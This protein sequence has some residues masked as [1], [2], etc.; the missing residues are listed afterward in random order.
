MPTD[1]QQE[2]FTDRLKLVQRALALR[3]GLSWP[4]IA[5]AVGVPQPTLERWL[6]AYRTG[7]AEA[8]M[9]EWDNA[10]RPAVADCLTTTAV[11]FLKRKRLKC[12]STST[13]LWHFQYDP[14]C[15]PEL[16]E[17]LKNMK[18]I[19]LSL[20][21]ACHVSKEAE[22]Q[23][24]GPTAHQHISFKD[25]HNPV[26]IDPATGAER[27][28]LAGD[29]YISDDMSRNMPFWFEL[30][31]GERETRARRGDKLAERHGVAVGR[32]G[33][34]TMDARGKLLGFTLIGCAR[35]A[36]TADD[37]LRHFWNIGQEFGWPRLQWVLEK[38]VWC[39]RTIDG[40]RVQCP[41]EMRSRIVS[42]FGQLGFNVDHVHT[43]EGKALL[44]SWFNFFQ[45]AQSLQEGAPDIGRVRGEMEREKELMRR[46]QNG[47][48]PKEE[49]LPYYADAMQLDRKTCI[50]LNS[51]EKYGRI[52]NGV[53]DENWVRDT[54]APESMLRKP[55]RSDRGHFL[56]TKLETAVRQGH[57]EKKIEG[58]WFRFSIPDKFGLLGKDYRVLMCFD[59]TDPE[60]GAEIFNLETGSRNQANLRHMEW[61][62][63]AEFSP[64]LPMFGYSNEVGEAAD[65]R[66][67]YQR[68][69]KNGYA[70]TGVFGY[71][72]ATQ[73]EA[74]DGRGNVVRVE[75]GGTAPASIQNASLPS[76]GAAG[77]LPEQSPGGAFIADA[78][79]ARRAL[80]K[81][82]SRME[83]ANA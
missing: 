28:L 60:S 35:D 47:V 69:F 37:V 52:Q 83:L 65:R 13:T 1:R 54:T 31:L 55:V 48:H 72:A 9:P 32:Q 50:A 41:D 21:K 78:P 34:F 36:Y 62:G 42:G 80:P 15:P 30:A 16:A 23:Y 6:R 38:G 19:P 14:L 82:R 43:S 25:T 17:K 79:P 73:I 59:P 68:A 56:S 75:S 77:V 29:I 51:R 44:E 22:A 46:V 10:G 76:R 2:A 74:R 45:R 33:L 71:R 70:G 18:S 27:A 81:I 58:D 61:M 63:S 4:K 26:V 3:P 66:K 7:G 8:L 39:A 49:G 5:K 64:G 12:G 11:N 40:T 67:R 24:R 57:V 53:P 20:R